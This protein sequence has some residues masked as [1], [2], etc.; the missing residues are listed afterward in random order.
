MGAPD[1]SRKGVKLPAL[2]GRV[3]RRE[4]DPRTGGTRLRFAPLNYGGQARLP[5]ARGNETKM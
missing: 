4:L 1:A 2:Y 3:N 5:K